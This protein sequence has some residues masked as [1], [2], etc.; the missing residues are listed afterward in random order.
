MALTDRQRRLYA[1]APRGEIGRTGLSLTHPAFGRAWHLTTAPKPFEGLVGGEL[2]T[3][4]VHPFKVVRPEIGTSGKV[5]MKLTLHN[6]GKVFAGEFLAAARQ[7]ETGIR[8]EVNDYLPGDPESQIDPI[9]LTL[10]DIG[11][12]PENCSA[13]ASS[14]DFLNL[15]FPRQ[16]YTLESHPGLDR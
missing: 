12:T 11:I 13:S 16:I 3:F 8:A 10:K 9:V 2:V 7:P 1:S 4:E 5:D 15:E 14:V 6:S